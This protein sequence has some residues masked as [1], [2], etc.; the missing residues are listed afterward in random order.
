MGSEMCI[1]DSPCGEDPLAGNRRRVLAVPPRDRHSMVLR[2]RRGRGR[3][4]GGEGRGEARG[5]GTRLSFRG[6]RPTDLPTGLLCGTGRGRG[7]TI[8]G[9]EKR[10]EEGKREEEKKE[11]EREK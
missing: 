2:R 10:E 5:R 6:R 8:E 3:V 7:T 4:V 11:E 9:E 1:R